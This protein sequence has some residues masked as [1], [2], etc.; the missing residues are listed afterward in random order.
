MPKVEETA[1]RAIEIDE[2]LA[3]AHTALA[4]AL[5]SYRR[6]WERAQEHFGLALRFDPNYSTARHWYALFLAAQGHFDQALRQIN[7]AQELDPVSPI[8]KAGAARCYYYT[9]KDS[10]TWQ[11]RV[12]EVLSEW[13]RIWLRHALG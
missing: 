13:I 1:R 10:M 12:T 9:T 11:S 8:I 4:N 6:D 5:F 7:R 2:T 3:E